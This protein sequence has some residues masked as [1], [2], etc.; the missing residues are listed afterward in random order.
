[1]I[2][3]ALALAFAFLPG[4]VLADA[5]EG[6]VYPFDLAA[7]QPALYKALEAAIPPAPG[8][9]GWLEGLKGVSGPTSLVRLGEHDFLS[10]YV[11]KP[12]DCRANRLVFIV[13][14]DGSRAATLL[15]VSDD[16][17]ERVLRGGDTTPE[18]EAYLQDRLKD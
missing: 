3:T 4:A 1:M 2:R 6:G 12:Q 11:C 15:Q 18:E 8:S 10:G 7:K 16:K 17:G 5:V 9:E 14:G 13:E